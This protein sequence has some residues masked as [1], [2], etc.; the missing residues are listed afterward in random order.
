M[1]IRGILSTKY[2]TLFRLHNVRICQYVWSCVCV[3]VPVLIDVCFYRWS[4]ILYNFPYFDWDY[5][6]N[7]CYCTPIRK[8]QRKKCWP[9]EF[10]LLLILLNT[11]TVSFTIVCLITAEKRCILINK[12]LCHYLAVSQLILFDGVKAKR[13]KLAILLCKTKSL[14]YNENTTI[15]WSSHGIF[16][17]SL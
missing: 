10:S 15:R 5:A 6:E 16:S 11:V 7:C 13:N 17:R 1:K 12:F 4:C 2:T 9:S 3:R 8:T 14:N